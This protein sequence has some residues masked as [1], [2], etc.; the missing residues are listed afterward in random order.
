MKWRPAFGLALAALQPLLTRPALTLAKPVRLKGPYSKARAA[1]AAPRPS[2]HSASGS[3]L[4]TMRRDCPAWRAEESRGRK[5]SCCIGQATLGWID[6]V[7]SAF[8]EYV[9]RCA[10]STRRRCVFTLA[11]VAS[12]RIGGPGAGAAASHAGHHPGKRGITLKAL[13][14]TMVRQ[15]VSARKGESDDSDEHPSAGPVHRVGGSGRWL[16]VALP[17]AGAAREAGRRHL[18]PVAQGRRQGRAERA[19]PHR[20]HAQARRA[21][22]PVVFD[23]DLQSQA[24][25]HLRAAD[26]REDHACGPGVRAA[27]QGR[28]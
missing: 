11:P 22:Q 28:R 14:R 18:L 25:S 5:I 16:A 27:V 23:A 12:G 24:R 3:A 4:R 19:L 21:H 2:A 1:V 26:H 9:R 7:E 20:G 6:C 17:A 15:A 8:R 13:S 10:A